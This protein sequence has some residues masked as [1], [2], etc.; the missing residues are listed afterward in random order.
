MEHMIEAISTGLVV[1]AAVGTFNALR[2]RVKSKWSRWRKSRAAAAAERA[3]AREHE[4][5]Q[6]GRDAAI[7]AAVAEGRIVPVA[8]DGNHPDAVTFS[9]GSLAHF[10]SGDWEA[11]RRAMNSGQFDPRRTHIGK[12]PPVV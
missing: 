2:P 6:R 9:D 8:R 11:Y 5:R 3:T 12:P 1:A 4:Q 7:A 10:F